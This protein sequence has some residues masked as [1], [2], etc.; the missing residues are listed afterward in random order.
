VKRAFFGDL[1]TRVARELDIPIILSKKYHG[2]VKSWFQK[3]F[4]SMK[5][6]LD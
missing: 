3:F 1:P 4:G 5:T 6:M 2:H